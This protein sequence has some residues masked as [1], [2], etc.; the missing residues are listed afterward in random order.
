MFLISVYTNS[1]LKHRYYLVSTCNPFDRFFG[2]GS[3]C[4]RK[5]IFYF[6]ERIEHAVF[7]RPFANFFPYLL[8]RIPLFYQCL[9]SMASSLRILYIFITHIHCITPVLF[10]RYICLE[11]VL[12]HH[13]V[14]MLSQ[15]VCGNCSSCFVFMEEMMS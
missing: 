13:T 10:Y 3:S 2:Q 1:K 7:E 9:V 11:L 12:V 8:Y 5:G 14:A 6:L 4:F 15:S